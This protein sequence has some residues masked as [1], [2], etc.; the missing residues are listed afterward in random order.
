MD[1]FHENDVST[2]GSSGDSWRGGSPGAVEALGTAKNRSVRAIMQGSWSPRAASREAET[3]LIR[4]CCIILFFTL[5]LGGCPWLLSPNEPEPVRV[6]TYDAPFAVSINSQQSVAIDQ[7]DP[8][9]GS[10]DEVIVTMTVSP[11]PDYN[12]SL[13]EVMF[14]NISGSDMPA[15]TV[16]AD[17]ATVLR[18]VRGPG[19]VLELAYVATRISGFTSF[20]TEDGSQY[21]DLVQILLPGEETR[22][23]TGSLAD[24]GFVGTGTVELQLEYNIYPDVPEGIIVASFA[25]FDSPGQITI[26]Y[27]YTP[28]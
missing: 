22:A 24:W 15:V 2:F 26:E 12:K 16:E 21:Y 10:L 20:G 5:L 18:R 11:D 17:M 27:V 19:E 13:I 9:L 14:W 1:T 6:T 4:R 3:R 7:F 28:D 25:S 23:Q 8:A